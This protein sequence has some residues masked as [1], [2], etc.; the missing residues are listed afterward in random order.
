V[1]LFKINLFLVKYK[2]ICS[3]FENEFCIN[4]NQP[5]FD[6]YFK[7]HVNFEKDEFVYKEFIE[8][9]IEL[10]IENKDN[11][12]KISYYEMMSF[13]CNSLNNF[14]K[15]SKDDLKKKILEYHKSEKLFNY[16]LY[17]F[18]LLIND[19]YFSKVLKAF[20]KITMTHFFW[21]QYL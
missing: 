1:Y 4:P 14:E 2:E 11:E 17:F 21:I 5:A 18:I 8:H 12:N 16:S 19:S 6:K 9:L 3:Y 7:P 13:L 10:H 15:N 20:S